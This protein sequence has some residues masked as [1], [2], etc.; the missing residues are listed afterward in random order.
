MKEFL[1]EVRD[2]R[3]AALEQ[4]I[5]SCKELLRKLKAEVQGN[6]TSHFVNLG[7]EAQLKNVGKHDSTQ[8]Q[9]EDDDDRT[10]AKRQKILD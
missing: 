10:G 4:Q 2:S 1:S 8:N 6:Q 3:I 9:T 5:V 7:Y